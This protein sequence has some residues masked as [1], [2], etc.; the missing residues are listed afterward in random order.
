MCMQGVAEDAGALNPQSSSTL[1]SSTHLVCSSSAAGLHN[2]GNTCF[3]NSALQLLLAC[4]P[5]QQQLLGAGDNTTNGT[6]TSSSDVG[7]SLNG[8]GSS[9]S[10]SAG[11]SAGG[12]SAA[13]VY[14]KGPL[15]YALQQAFLHTA[16]EALGVLVWVWV[17][18]RG[19][20]WGEH[21]WPRTAGDLSSRQP[22]AGHSAC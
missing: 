21:H 7:V 22:A 16:G 10:G 14:S 9:S 17:W 3:F 19:V 1:S 18:V 6:S 15:G 12:G 5:L 20:N 8:G 2:L 11:H 13:A 4:A